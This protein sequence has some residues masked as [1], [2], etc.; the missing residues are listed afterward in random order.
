MLVNQ[1]VMDVL[2]PTKMIYL[3]LNILY[4]KDHHFHLFFHIPN[5]QKQL[6]LYN[7]EPWY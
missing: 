6:S 3:D 2:D 1:L 7:M 4:N 5:D